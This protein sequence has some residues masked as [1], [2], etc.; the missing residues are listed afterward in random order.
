VREWF[1]ARTA[2]DDGSQTKLHGVRKA[3]KLARY[4]VEGGDDA[5]LAAEY[6]N[7]QN[8]GGG[9]HDS[10][11]LRR[12]AHDHLGKHSELV[13]IF[14]GQEDAMLA[15]FRMTLGRELPE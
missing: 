1:A 7:I 9:W 14:A 15:E 13:R 2:D 10:L 6:E 8:I 5:A 11:T 4:M 3:A 12:T